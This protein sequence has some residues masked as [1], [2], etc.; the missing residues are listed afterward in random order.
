[1]RKTPMAR[2]GLFLILMV[3]FSCSGGGKNNDSVLDYWCSNNIGEITFSNDRVD[4]WN[5]TYPESKVSYQPIPEGQSSEE[6]ILAAV[7]GKTTPDIYSS[8]WQGSVELYARANV[9]FALDTLAGFVEFIS[10]RCDSLTISEITSIDGHIYQVP[11]KINPFMTIYN[12]KFLTALNLDSLPQ[13]Y[14]EYLSAA[15]RFKKDLDEDGY[16]D[17]WFGNTSVKLVWYQRL[18]NFYTLYIAASDGLPLIR[19]NRA[20]FNNEYGIEV[21]RFLQELY[22]QDYFSKEQQ[23]SSRDPFIA[24]KIATKFTGPWEIEFLE[25]YKPDG[26]EYGFYPMLVPDDH[27]GPIYTYCDPK[28]IVVFSTC[29]DPELAFEF[30][31]TMVDESGDLLFLQTTKQLPRRAG[32]DTLSAFENFFKENAQLRVF[33]E[34]AK[35]IRGI[36]NCEVIVEVLDIITQEYEACVIYNIKEPEEAL[37]DA[38]K[39]VNVILGKQ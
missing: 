14:S 25:R 35:Y 2:Y 36:D 16:I 19:N 9:L 22:K 8:M 28:S 20:F 6:I 5:L 27:K 33:A 3:L 31:K 29:E 4:A 12:R 10:G 17:Q 26:F 34:Q 13:T 18:F 23:S 37:A 7:V 15:E 24:G 38:E 21:F 30:I 39:A 1:M 11:W 32:L